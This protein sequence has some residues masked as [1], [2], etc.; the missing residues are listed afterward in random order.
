MHSSYSK[1][2]LENDYDIRSDNIF[3]IHHPL[4]NKVRKINSKKYSDL[5]RKKINILYFGIINKYKGVDI[6]LRSLRFLDE[7]ILSQLN[8]NIAGKLLV[9]RNSILEISKKY[10]LG[11][12]VNFNFGWIDENTKEDLFEN[13]HLVVL[14]YLHIDGSGVLADAFEYNLPVI[15]SD[16]GSFSELIIENEM[17]YLFDSANEKALS[18]TIEKMIENKLYLVNMSQKI[19]DLA[20]KI[21]DWDVTA[22]KILEIYSSLK[23]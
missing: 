22:N 21:D 2:V 23:K 9:K 17:G 13:A 12:Y 5:D 3:I 10:N 4:F 6:F 15:A 1:K 19:S 7:N 18:L 8:I 14:P 11:K 16:I 20:R